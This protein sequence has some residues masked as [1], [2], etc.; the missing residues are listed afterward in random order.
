MNSSVKNDNSVIIE[1]CSVPYSKLIWFLT[2]KSYGFH[3]LYLYNNISIQSTYVFSSFWSELAEKKY[4]LPKK[5]YS[6]EC[7]FMFKKIH[8]HLLTQTFMDMFLS[9]HKKPVRLCD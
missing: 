4:L 9:K 1:L 3:I 2:A 8:I 6:V 7:K 5:S